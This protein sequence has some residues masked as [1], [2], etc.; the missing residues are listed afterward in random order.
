MANGTQRPP[1]DIGPQVRRARERAG[2]KQSDLAIAS[3]ISQATISE[4]EAGHNPNICLATLFQLACGLKIRRW[5]T[6]L[7]RVEKD[8][9]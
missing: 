1:H 6:I 7:G 8:A 4:L 9:S 2:M 3:G 5:E